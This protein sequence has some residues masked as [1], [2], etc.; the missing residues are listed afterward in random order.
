MTKEVIKEIKEELRIVKRKYNY[1]LAEYKNAL[2]NLRTY[3]SLL[4]D[5]IELLYENPEE[6][7]KELK[8]YKKVL[9]KM[10]KS[11]DDK[12]KEQQERMKCQEE[13]KVESIS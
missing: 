3:S 9:M 13:V 2:L 4:R 5:S 10:V 11:I 7:V 1:R 12:I 8:S 6:R